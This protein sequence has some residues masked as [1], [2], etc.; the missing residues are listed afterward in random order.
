ML[1]LQN[2]LKKPAPKVRK[3]QALKKALNLFS[4]MVIMTIVLMVTAMVMTTVVTMVMA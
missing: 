4:M 2:R 3:S 1:M